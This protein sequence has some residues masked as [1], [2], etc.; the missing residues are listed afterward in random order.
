MNTSNEKKIVVKYKNATQCQTVPATG[1]WGG[2]NPQ[3]EIICHFFVEHL[4]FP[5]DAEFVID[6]DTGNLIREETG[7]VSETVREVQVS[8]VM[9]PDIAKTIGEWLVN[10]TKLITPVDSK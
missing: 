1:A 9:R 5:Q 4:V 2:L 10:K 6:K 3:G 8:V 7:E